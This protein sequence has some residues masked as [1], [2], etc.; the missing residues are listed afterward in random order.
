M[1]LGE[2]FESVMSAAQ[3][4]AEW[5]VTLLYR[6]LHP[7]VLGYL[8]TQQP[9]EGDDL[10]SETWLDVARSLPR[11]KGGEGD[12]RRWVFAIARRRLIDFRRQVRR[13]RTEPVPTEA[14][15]DQVSP[16][17]VEEEVMEGM[18]TREALARISSLPQEQS[19]VV[20]LR[21]VGGFSAKE[22][23]RIIGKRPGTVRVLQHR[24]LARLARDLA[25][26]PVTGRDSRA[27]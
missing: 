9:G 17:D 27:M 11:F 5:A 18:S 26:E 10:E 8:R 23:G 22:V 2:Q 19:E 3:T 6:D 13:R 12:F 25:R 15:G 24:A 16:G 1:S 7:A 14:L 20:L 21:V 4:G